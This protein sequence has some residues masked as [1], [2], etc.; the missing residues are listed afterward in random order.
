MLGRKGLSGGCG[1]RRCPEVL[2]GGW[3]MS[4]VPHLL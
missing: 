2:W 4:L 1:A 3:D